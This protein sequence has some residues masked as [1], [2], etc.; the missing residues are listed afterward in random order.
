M[1][2]KIVTEADRKATP[3]PALPIGEDDEIQLGPYR[4]PFWMAMARNTSLGSC[5]SLASLVLPA[6]LTA[7]GLPVGLEF[8]ALQGEDRRVLGLGLAIET[9]LGRQSRPQT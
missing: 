1:G 9:V 3:R 2:N 6:G 4:M 7:Q 5:A 8:S